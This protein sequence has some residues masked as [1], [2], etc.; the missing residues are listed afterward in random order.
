MNGNDT[1]SGGECLGVRAGYV[2]D[3]ADQLLTNGTGVG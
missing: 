2:I 3:T 1:V